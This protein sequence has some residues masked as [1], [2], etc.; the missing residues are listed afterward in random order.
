[1]ATDKFQHVVPQRFD[2]GGHA[3]EPIRYKTGR[4]KRL[5]CVTCGKWVQRVPANDGPEGLKALFRF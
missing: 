4:V 2:E 1:M 3:A 5:V